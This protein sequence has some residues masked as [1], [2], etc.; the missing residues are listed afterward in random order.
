M[1][2]PVATS[3]S[4]LIKHEWLA[5][6]LGFYFWGRYIVYTY[7]TYGYV[8]KLPTQKGTHTVFHRLIPSR[9]ASSFFDLGESIRSILLEPP[10]SSFFFL[11]KKAWLKYF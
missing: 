9:S 8:S 11:K 1:Q 4:L 7:D 3:P 2:D 5:S 10:M 6:D